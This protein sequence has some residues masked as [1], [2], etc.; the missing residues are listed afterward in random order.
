MKHQHY[1]I[2]RFPDHHAINSRI[3][4]CFY[5]QRNNEQTRN[6]HF[7]GGR[8]ENIYIDSSLLHGIDE[9]TTFW[10]Q[11]AADILGLQSKDLRSGFWFNL[12]APGDT[13]TLHSHDDDDELLSGVYYLEVPA[14]NSGSLVLHVGEKR[15]E[16]EP[17]AGKLV[18]FAPD[19]LH[20][21]TENRSNQSRLSI[22]INFG[23][24]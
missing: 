12:M 9:L 17:E 10:R 20:E 22:G 7:F 1:H 2:Y 11:R 24:S 19:C 14:S 8:Y 18:L 6:S 16:I 5:D 21:V 23:P 15:I 13:T 4:R 3:V